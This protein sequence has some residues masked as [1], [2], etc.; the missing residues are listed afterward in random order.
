MIA[1]LDSDVENPTESVQHIMT[2]AALF[3]L[4]TISCRLTSLWQQMKQTAS[5]L[6]TIVPNDLYLPAPALYCPQTELDHQVDRL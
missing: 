1:L 2:P 3:G 6:S 5:R 4:H